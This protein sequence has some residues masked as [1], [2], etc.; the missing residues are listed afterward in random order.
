MAKKKKKVTQSDKMLDLF[1]G[2]HFTVSF[3]GAIF[4]IFGGAFYLMMV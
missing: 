4:A 2:K 1:Q 3:F